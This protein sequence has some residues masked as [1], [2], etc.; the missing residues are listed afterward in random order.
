MWR[1]IPDTQT[2]NALNP[3]PFVDMITRALHEHTVLVCGFV[4]GALF[5]EWRHPMWVFSCSVPIFELENTLDS[6]SHTHQAR[7]TPN[8]PVFRAWRPF[9]MQ[10]GGLTP[11]RLYFLYFQLWRGLN[12]QGCEP[13][14]MFF[15]HQGGLHLPHLLLFSL[16]LDFCHTLY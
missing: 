8:I 3:P 4:L 6:F 7:N 11:F 10:R 14:F 9:S 1:I 16:G 12:T 13:S 5:W 2:P 15:T